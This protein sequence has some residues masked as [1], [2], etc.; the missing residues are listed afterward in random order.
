MNRIFIFL[1]YLLLVHV[2]FGQENETKP[3][4]DTADLSNLSIEELSKLK[5]RY[6]ATDM[7]KSIIQ[8]IGAAS[9]KPLPLRK[10]PSIVSVIM[11]DEIEKSGARDF[12]DLL[13]LIPGVELNVDVEGVVALSFRGMWANEGNILL[14]ID[15]Q[16]VNET[17]FAGLQF[18]N[19]Y[20][21]TQI[22]K[23]EIIR[24]PGSAIYGGFAEYAV[25]N[26]VTKCGKEIDGLTGNL[27]AGQTGNGFAHQ[28]IS[29]AAGQKVNDFSYSIHALAGRGQR[30]T[31]IYRDVH[32][33]TY[34]M[35]GNSSIRN[36]FLD[37]KLAYNN[38]SFLFIYDNYAT[39][40]RDGY[41][42]ALTKTYPCNFTSYMSEVKYKK[43][44]SPKFQFQTKLSWKRTLP[45][46]FEG[47][48][49]PID[50]SYGH[51]KIIADRYRANV[52]VSWDPVSWLNGVAGVEGLLDNAYKPDGQL[53]KADSTTRVNYF[54]YAPFI[55]LLMKTRFA[56]VTVGARYDVS[57]AFGSAFNPRLGITRK[58]GRFNFKLLYAA[59]FRAPSIEDI[60][61]SLNKVMLNPEQSKTLEFETSVKLTKDMFL[62]VNIFDV[63]TKNAIRYFVRMDSS[64]NG[65]PNG[66]RNTRNVIGSQGVE[67]EYKYKSSFGFINFLYS[68]Y[69]IGNKKC[70]SA[71]AV[72]A[73]RNSTLGIAQSKFTFMASINAGKYLFITPSVNFLGK[74]YGY[75]HVDGLGNAIL[76]AFQPQMAF[77]L[78][79][80]C[81]RLL[82]NASFGVG[83]NNITDE[84]IVYLQAYNSMHAPLPG[85]GRE[86][87]LKFN[88]NFPFHSKSKS[89]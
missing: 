80:G 2:S 21:I 5:S 78:Y 19:H 60:Q 57:S 41:V 36:G 63:T 33:K 14:Q 65:D 46:E 15:G 66:Y 77:N 18:G 84:R 70:D 50:S 6:V 68:Y 64:N 52:N 54:N 51:Y 35:N 86:F 81:E 34:D 62:S 1:M 76:S 24:G 20:P 11:E 82:K 40:I 48:P 8:A 45:W 29:V 61:Y 22:K 25:I 74:R 30:S 56:N 85:L 13:K 87:Y 12:I 47:Q 79:A 31:D 72:V 73:N 59:S 58:F 55:Q 7:E 37:V 10:T 42:G 3:A 88:Y 53:F 89:D 4:L 26:V 17:A 28:N 16:E 49:A 23:I 38:L 39:E 69:T 27:L 67:F 75:T 43:E 83:V 44:W 71:N 32:D 9:H